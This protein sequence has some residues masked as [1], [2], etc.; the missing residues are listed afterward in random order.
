MQGKRGENNG[1]QVF[2]K[3]TG[4]KIIIDDVTAK[5]NIVKAGGFS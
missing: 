3:F 1:H 2:R 4:G 5:L